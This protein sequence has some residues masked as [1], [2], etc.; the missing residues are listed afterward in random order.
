MFAR[1]VLAGVNHHH[2]RAADRLQS[3]HA[4]RARRDG[5]ADGKQE[6]ECAGGFCERKFV[7][8]RSECFTPTTSARSPLDTVWTRTAGEV[9]ASRSLTALSMAPSS[10][11]CLALAEPGRV[12]PA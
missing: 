1:D 3:D 9:T 10:L 12:P 4:S 7:I 5:A 11:A 2:Q 6:K 8:V